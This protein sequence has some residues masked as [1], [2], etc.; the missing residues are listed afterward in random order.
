MTLTVI[1]GNKRWRDTM[2]YICTKYLENGKQR[3][4]R[5][6]SQMHHL[7]RYQQTTISSTF[8][9]DTVICAPTCTALACHTHQTARAK[10][11]QPHGT[12]CS[13]DPCTGKPG[14]SSS[15]RKLKYRRSCGVPKNS[16]KKP[17]SFHPL[18]KR[19]GLRSF[20]TGT[21]EKSK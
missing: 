15:H 1:Y 13:L 10:V 18:Y 5:E 12:S 11:P 19:Q 14:A 6:A 20:L 21:Q 16:L 2:T 8:V 9:L 7:S 17:S 3:G 4:G